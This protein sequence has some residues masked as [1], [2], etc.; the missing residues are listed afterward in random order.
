M[1]LKVHPESKCEGRPCV[2]HN[3]LPGHMMSWPINF[4]SDLGI[5]ERI[6]PHGVGHPCE[7]DVLWKKSMGQDWVVVHSCD[8]CCVPPEGA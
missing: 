7:E 4:R 5:S 1:L 2:V 3:P 6:C 8:G